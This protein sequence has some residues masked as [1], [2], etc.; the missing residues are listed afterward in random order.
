MLPLLLIIAM[1][2]LL[3]LFQLWWAAAYWHAYRQLRAPVLLVQVA[4][5]LVYTIFFIVVLVV[6]ASG[7]AVNRLSVFVLMVL[8]IITTVAWRMMGGPALLASNYPRGS[9]DLLAFRRPAV[10]LKRRVRGK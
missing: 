3:T 7:S 9:R 5:G 1:A 8:V 2:L 6:F 4:Q 10:D